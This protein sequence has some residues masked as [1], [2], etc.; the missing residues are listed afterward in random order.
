M[1]IESWAN[2]SKGYNGRILLCGYYN[3]CHAVRLARSQRRATRGLH[4]IGGT[5]GIK[6]VLVLGLP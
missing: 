5:E 4:N 3:F 1:V 2:A 6:M